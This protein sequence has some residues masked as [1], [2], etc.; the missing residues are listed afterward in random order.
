MHLKENL[1]RGVYAYVRLGKG[2]RS[3]VTFTDS[4]SCVGVRKSISRSISWQYPDLPR[5]RHYCAGS[6]RHGQDGDI[7]HRHLAGHRYRREGDA[8]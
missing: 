4:T 8:R 2:Y 7:Q 3:R 6:V 5:E 1:L